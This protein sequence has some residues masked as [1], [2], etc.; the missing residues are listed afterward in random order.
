MLTFNDLTI[1]KELDRE[2]MAEIAGGMEIPQFVLNLFSAHNEP[3]L[4]ELLGIATATTGEQFNTNTQS[5]NDYNVVIG[6]GQ[7]INMGGNFNTT[8]QDAY[9]YANNDV[10]SSQ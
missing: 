9:A 5:D 6:S 3:K 2:A 1:S 7:V 4:A 10:R 8:Y